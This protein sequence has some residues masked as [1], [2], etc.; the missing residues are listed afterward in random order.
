VSVPVVFSTGSLHPFG[1]GR[2]FG[3]AAEAGFDGVEVMMDDR[4]DTHQPAYLG[5]LVEKHGL[6]IL[7][8]HPPIYAGAWRLGRA[9]TLV[10][11]ARLARRVSCPLVVAHP[12]PPG[13]PLRR[14]AA[15]PLAAAREYATVAVENMPANSP[16]F[17]GVR[18]GS[19][20]LP[21]HL[22]GVG[23]VALDTSH[24]G[25]SGVD[26]PWARE[27][28][29]GQLRHVHLS[30][31]NLVVGKDDHRL[32]G[33]GLLPLKPF[34]AALA[35]DGY[36][37]AVSLELKPWPLGTPDPDVIL[38]RMRAALEFTRDGLRGTAAEVS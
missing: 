14:W 11:S 31:S 15:G 10:R 32:P 28:L 27:A 9:E 2:V 38:A 20:H 17:F 22:A 33:K 8:L 18:R 3:W 25:A 36:P 29:A 4:W 16:G 1:L 26:L 12:P 19:C 35:A 6:P 21:E 30:D 5:E 7:A 24:V 34:L 13:P 37:G 23:D